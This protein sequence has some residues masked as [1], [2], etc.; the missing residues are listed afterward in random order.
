MNLSEIVDE[1]M[2][3]ELDDER[4][5]IKN[6][7]SSSYRLAS[8][9]ERELDGEEWTV[10]YCEL[11]RGNAIIPEQG[12]HAVTLVTNNMTLETRVIEVA[13]YDMYGTRIADYVEYLDSVSAKCVDQM[14]VRDCYKYFESGTYGWWSEK[15]NDIYE[16][17]HKELMARLTQL[18]KMSEEE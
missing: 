15:I 8:A 12:P 10:M 17:E 5:E 3:G 9:L 11:Y 1:I 7:F 16:Q 6:C 14:L 2:H 4:A 18:Q 13:N